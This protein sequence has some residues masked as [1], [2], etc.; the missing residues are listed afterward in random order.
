M[1]FYNYVAFEANMILDTCHNLSKHK[2]DHTTVCYVDVELRLTEINPQH[3][4]GAEI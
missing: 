3:I 2:N 4:L 1:Y